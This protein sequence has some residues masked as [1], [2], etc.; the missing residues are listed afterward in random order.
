MAWTKMARKITGDEQDLLFTSQEKDT[1]TLKSTTRKLTVKRSGTLA[2]GLRSSSGEKAKNMSG[3]LFPFEAFSG[4]LDE[5][6]P[7]VFTEQNF[8]VEFFHAT[9]SENLDFA[10][11]VNAAAPYQR[12]G[13]NLLARRM[14]E[15][16]RAMAKRVIESMEAIF[17]WWQGELQ[18]TA[19]GVASNDPL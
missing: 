18:N 10:D 2:R 3:T 15:P 7:L 17:G 9:S 12:K 5:M 13:S 8:V 4:A 19:D 14:F 6:C 1:E 11:A 16:D